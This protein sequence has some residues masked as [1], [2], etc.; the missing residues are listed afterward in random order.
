MKS[1]A[2]LEQVNLE[3]EGNTKG[4]EECEKIDLTQHIYDYVYMAMWAAVI[5]LQISMEQNTSNQLV[6]QS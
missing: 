6:I 1:C 2:H 4:C 3:T 5:L